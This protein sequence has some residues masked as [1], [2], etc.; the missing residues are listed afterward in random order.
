MYS[1]KHLVVSLL[2]QSSITYADN[3]RVLMG[4][5]STQNQTP[6]EGRVNVDE[7][8]SSL[9]HVLFAFAEIDSKTNSCIILD[10]Q[11]D[12]KDTSSPLL[13]SELK[14]NSTSCAADQQA[15]GNLGAL[16]AFKKKNPHVQVLLSVGG[17]SPERTK[18]FA[19]STSTDAGVDTLA[20]SCIKMAL[21]YGL[22]GVDWD[23]E[24][25]DGTGQWENYLKL[26]TATRKYLNEFK[27]NKTYLQTIAILPSAL[28]SST[29]N[30]AA[31]DVTSLKKMSDQLDFV[32][33]MTYDSSPGSDR[34]LHDS[35]LFAAPDSWGAH[36]MND[37][38]TRALTLI[39]A[40]KLVVG[41]PLYG[42]QSVVV[43]FTRDSDKSS[44]R[45]LFQKIDT[46]K[47]NQGETIWYNQIRDNYLTNSDF[48]RYWDDSSK[49]PYLFNSNTNTFITYTDSESLL[50]VAQYIKDKNLAGIFFWHLGGSY[51]RK[52][53]QEELVDFV[54]SKLD[55]VD[56]RKRHVCAPRSPFCNIYS[57][58]PASTNGDN[59]IS[60][61]FKSSIISPLSLT[62]LLSFTLALITV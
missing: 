57:T 54:A 39:P 53:K 7:M 55:K 20:K 1:I 52:T 23:W 33:L 25:P 5:I 16:Y 38:V 10:D 18:A 59:V 21:D 14:P 61:N 50:A 45:G 42:R 49:S 44:N 62:L 43:P 47:S 31:A 28:T 9:T 36:S 22:D 15:K 46:S 4:Y 6:V 30:G 19:D 3:G 48:V 35:P 12:T 29:G 27:D 56:M 34:A 60:G 58:C 24:T 51:N 32:N 8:P 37:T 13:S 41:S 2:L 26:T 40:N 17:A 11:M